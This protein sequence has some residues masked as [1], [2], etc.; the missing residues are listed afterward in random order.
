MFDRAPI[1]ASC[2]IQY[3]QSG[4]AKP[5]ADTRHGRTRISA[6]GSFTRAENCFPKS[7][8]VLRS[9]L[10]PSR[11]SVFPWCSPKSVP[12]SAVR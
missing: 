11:T 7:N 1:F 3:L 8:G 10:E 9:F 2:R 4:Y 5:F 6:T 12:S